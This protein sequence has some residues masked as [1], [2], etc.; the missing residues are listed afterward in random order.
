MPAI[1]SQLGQPT[2]VLKSQSALEHSNGVGG[3][4]VNRKAVRDTF[5]D[6]VTKIL[7]EFTSNQESIEMTCLDTPAI[8]DN[9]RY[10]LIKVR[11]VL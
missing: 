9:Q 10:F 3:G 11:Y 5:A 8:R 1:N 4:I 7:L 2:G 6:N